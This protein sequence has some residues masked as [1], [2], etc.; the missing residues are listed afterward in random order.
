LEV[1]NAKFKEFVDAGGY[2]DPKYWRQ[3]FR[4]NGSELSFDRA[5]AK[6]GDV[7]GR[8]APASWQLGVYPT[9]QGEFPVS[10]VSWFEA[11]AYCESVGKALP[12]V[13][14]WRRA[15]G[16]GLFTTILL[17][18]NFAGAGPA[19]VGRYAGISP[20]GAYDM[21]G[22]VKEWVWNG[23]G[24]R[25]YVLGGSWNEPSY[26]FHDPDA[27][28]PF[29][30]DSHIGF[31]CAQY[32]DPPPARTLAPIPHSEPYHVGRSPVDDKTFQIYQRRY[33][34]DKTP[35]EAKT[36][37]RDDKY[38]YWIKEKVTY[39]TVYGERM[40]AYLYLPRQAKPPYQAVMWAPGGYASFLPSSE[41]ALPR[42]EFAYLIRTGRAVL[43]PVYKGTYERRPAEHGPNVTR[44]ANVQFV[45]DIFQ[46]LTFLESRADI[47]KQRIAYKGYSLGAWIGVMAL[48][49]EPRFKAGVLICGG[50][51]SKPLDGELEQLNF[52]PR[53][54]VPTLMV[55]GRDDFIRPPN[56]SQ[57]PL[58]E[59]LGTP[60]SDKRLALFEGGH[61]PPMQGVMR[62][63]LEW[64]DKYLGSV[65][66]R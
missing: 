48:A 36:E 18:S 4:Q 16:F 38:E 21:A 12:T 29:L 55:G 64:L 20:F 63:T 6:F 47:D 42:E 19:P 61:I 45:K 65:G 28:N 56:V 54:H 15:A 30:R 59:L 41:G 66:K 3:A 46:S 62:E 14:H 11:A 50:L 31:R 34:Y 60:A 32:V 49:M 51:L 22:N 37:Y 5:V 53:V 40:A 1:T 24:D 25:R 26:M 8:T 7:T 35:L 57:R 9:G 58:F 44:E 2:R 52:A 27:Q 43:Y 17:H 13:P 33:A 39:R 10:G 23:A